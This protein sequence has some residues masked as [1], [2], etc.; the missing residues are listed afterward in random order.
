MTSSSWLNSM[1]SAEEDKDVN[2]YAP[3]SGSPFL[4]V[5]ALPIAGLLQRREQPGQ[6]RSSSVH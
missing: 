6:T 5:A 2:Y 4:A 1:T 3:F